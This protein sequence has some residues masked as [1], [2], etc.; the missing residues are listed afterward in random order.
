PDLADEVK[1]MMFVFEDILGI[2]DRA[3]QAIL[4]EVD[5]KELGLALKGV[6]DEVRN[7][8]FRNMSER[9]VNMLKE[10]MDYMGPVKVRQVEEAQQKIVAVIRRLEEAGEISI[11]RGEEEVLV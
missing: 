5:V 7:K 2:D 3:I 8:V 10:D 4:K 9:A 6:N 1:N 11:G